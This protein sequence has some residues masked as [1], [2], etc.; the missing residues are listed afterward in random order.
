[1]HNFGNET[2]TI[3]AHWQLDAHFLRLYQ[4]Y[5]GPLDVWTEGLRPKPAGWTGTSPELCRPEVLRKTEVYNDL[6]VPMD[7]EHGMFGVFQKDGERLSNISLYRSAASGEFQVSD[8]DILHFLIPHMQRAFKLHF[9]FSD[10]KARAERSETAL[11]LL[12]TALIFLDDKGDI[13]LMNRRAGDLLRRKDGLRL[14]HG[15]LIANLSS[16]SAALVS[17]IAKAAQTGNG[18]GFRAGGTTLI[19]REKRRPLSVTVAP[20]PS[21]TIALEKRPAA[22]LFIS[23]PDQSSEV[24]VDLLQRSY[25]LTAAEARLAV[26]LA[27]GRGLNEAAELSGVTHNTAKTQLKN[28]FA[29]TQVQRQGELIRLLL[30]SFPLAHGS[31]MST[32]AKNLATLIKRHGHHR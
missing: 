21:T 10:L 24:P 30:L 15:K 23:D 5:Y 13:L 19:T 27:E 3:A 4:E 12:S 7:I 18:K 25:G 31:G 32:P 14:E 16:E 2:H 28:V 8:L 1:M 29:K 20:L 11:D 17:T 9:E 22:V 26:L 6:M